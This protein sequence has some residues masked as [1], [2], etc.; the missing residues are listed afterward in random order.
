MRKIQLNFWVFVF[1]ALIYCIAALPAHATRDPVALKPVPEMMRGVWA[2]PDCF[3]PEEWHF[4]SEYF[5]FDTGS[6]GVITMSSAATLQNRDGYDVIGFNS[7]RGSYMPA[8]VLE[9]GVLQMVRLEQGAKLTANWDDLDA[10]VYQEYMHCFDTALPVG[11]ADLMTVS[12]KLDS[13]YPV[14]RNSIDNACSEKLFTLYMRDGRTSLTEDDIRK[15]LQDTAMFGGLNGT[16]NTSRRDIE[17]VAAGLM[18]IFDLDGSGDIRLDELQ[19]VTNFWSQP[20]LSGMQKHR[21]QSLLKGLLPYF[22]ALETRR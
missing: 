12:A 19:S 3:A 20:A 16:N 6:D 21:L 7:P 4:Y 15:I 17:S 13:V 8:R 14:C 2:A 5:R 1:G 11:L 10:A 9:D 18:Q 22:P